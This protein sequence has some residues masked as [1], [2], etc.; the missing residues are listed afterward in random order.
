MGTHLTAPSLR[1]SALLPPLL[2]E[3]LDFR[4]HYT[5][6]LSF[7]DLE[8]WRAI[9][10][11]D[12]DIAISRRLLEESLQAVGREGA[13]CRSRADPG[14]R[15]VWSVRGEHVSRN[16]Q[17]TDGDGGQPFHC[18]TVIVSQSFSVDHAQ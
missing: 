13:V 16:H 8:V 2:R 11:H 14:W 7:V 17:L 5:F 12:G 9:W 1:L 18:H 15:W 10:Q 4:I 3:G 6:L